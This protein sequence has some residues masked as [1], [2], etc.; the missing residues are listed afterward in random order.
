M[1]TNLSLVKYGT[2]LLFADHATDFVGGQPA[3]ANNSLVVGTPT[4][5]QMNLS[6]LATAAMWQSAKTGS[7]I[8]GGL[9]AWPEFW[10]LGACIENAATPTVN[11][12]WR[13]YWNASPSGTAAVGNSGATSG[14]DSAYTA[15]GLKRLIY[16]GAMTCRANVINIDAAIGI[17]RMPHPYGSLVVLNNTGVGMTADSVADETHITLTPIVPDFQAAA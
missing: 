8:P 7:L 15:D 1:T 12:T 14:T 13:F 2:Q 16:I 10:M 17:L 3:T 5:V 4:N 11:T 6:V 9:S